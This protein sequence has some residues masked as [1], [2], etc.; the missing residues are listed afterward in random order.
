MIDF[1]TQNASLSFAPPT[2]EQPAYT[3]GISEPI[4][5]PRAFGGFANTNSRIK[6]DRSVRLQFARPQARQHL[7]GQESQFGETLG[8]FQTV[9]DRASALQGGLIQADLVGLYAMKLDVAAN[10]ALE[11]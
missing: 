8:L 5:R 10:A 3:N 11:H 1:L 9:Q 4:P 7:R 2:I 6:R